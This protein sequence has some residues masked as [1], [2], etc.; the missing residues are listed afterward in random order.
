VV[1]RRPCSIAEARQA[2]AE[3]ARSPWLVFTDADVIFAPDYFAQ[4]QRNTQAAADA[5]YG[6]KLSLNHHARYDRWFA[7]AQ[8]WSHRL[9]V[10]AASGSNLVIRRSALM[11]V[12]GFDL[13]LRC[14]ED[15]E[16]A[17]RLKRQGCCVAFDPALVVYA[18][19]HRRLRRGVVGKT[20]HSATRCALLYLNLMPVR[21]R[22]GDWGYWRPDRGR[23]SGAVM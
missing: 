6:P 7:C 21:W 14:N 19:D 1:I 16:V 5:L 8:C 18:R 15:S 2:G 12:G 10:P 3:F 23:R 22:G 9:G 13:R 4:L 20:L 17:W 11:A